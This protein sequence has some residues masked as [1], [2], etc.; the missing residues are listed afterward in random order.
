MFYDCMV[1]VCA[2]NLPA[3]TKKNSAISIVGSHMKWYRG[4]HNCPPRQMADLDLD[5]KS[6]RFS[7][8]R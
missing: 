6:G 7:W 3:T 1:N 2:I 4:A 5:L 8:F